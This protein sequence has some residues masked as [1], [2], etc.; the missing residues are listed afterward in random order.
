MEAINISEG[1]V[2]SR[3]VT[4]DE[5]ESARARKD[6][7]WK[8][9]YA[10]HEPPQLQQTD[11]TYDGRSLAEKLA[12]NKIAKQEEWEAKN[13][14]A[15]QFRALEEDEIM[16]LD[17]IREKQEQEER[18]R[19]ETEGEELKNFRVAV[20]ARNVNPPPPVPGTSTSAAP[21][22]KPK[23]SQQTG[24]KPEG[25]RVLKGIVVKKKAPAKPA[26]AKTSAP[27]AEAK[28]PEKKTGDEDL[29]DPK[30]RKISKS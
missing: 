25:K 4:Q 22:P 6:E 9:A 5:I 7:Q 23:P 13:K 12:A 27:V 1:T 29:P 26:V 17:S 30:R 2:G 21:P 28:E 24:K 10:R 3:F 14:L 20:A 8:A 11:E 19:M 18:L 16:F 15:N